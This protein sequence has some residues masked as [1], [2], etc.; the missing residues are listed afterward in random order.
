MSV[1]TITEER[2][3]ELSWRTGSYMSEMLIQG[4]MSHYSPREESTVAQ[5]IAFEEI[6]LGHGF[7]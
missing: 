5:L 4:A 7:P 1:L 2:V 3:R 6:A